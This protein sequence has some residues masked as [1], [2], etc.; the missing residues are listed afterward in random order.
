MKVYVWS[1]SW[2]PQCGPFKE[3]LTQRGVDFEVQDA[4]ALQDEAVRIGIRSLP[5]TVF[6]DDNGEEMHRIPGNNVAKVM[7]YLQ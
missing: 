6:L 5:T 1:A 2:C 3:A 4:D 7:E